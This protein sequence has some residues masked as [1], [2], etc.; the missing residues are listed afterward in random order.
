MLPCQGSKLTVASSKF[1]T[2]KS[3]LPH[4]KNVGS[5][6]LL[7]RNSITTVISWKNKLTFSEIILL[8]I[9]QNTIPY[10]QR[11]M[12]F[13]LVINLTMGGSGFTL[14]PIIAT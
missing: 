10:G 9:R 8:F 1:A 7:P 12:E 4:V 6:K 2:L 3:H 14:L 13:C 5:K 11:H